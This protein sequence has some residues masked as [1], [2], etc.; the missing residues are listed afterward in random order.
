MEI[1]RRIFLYVEK[2]GSDKITDGNQFMSDR[3]GNKSDNIRY[4]TPILSPGLDAQLLEKTNLQ[5]GW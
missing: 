4:P 5:R 1:I 3:V 2:I